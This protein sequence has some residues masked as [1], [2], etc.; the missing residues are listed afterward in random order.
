VFVW[1][2]NQRGI[3]PQANVIAS[4]MFFVALAAVIIAQV[5]SARK[6]KALAK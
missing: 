5:N 4:L 1:T 6:A 2:S 3:P